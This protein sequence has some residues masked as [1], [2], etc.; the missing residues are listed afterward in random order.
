MTHYISTRGDCPPVPFDKAIIDGF[1]PDGGLY[2]P[3]TIPTFTP[4]DL[5][6]LSSLD[7]P[8][9]AQRIIRKFIPGSM[10][11]DKDLRNLLRA[12]FSPFSSPDTVPIVHLKQNNLYIQELFHGPTL[13]FK[14]I[15]MGFL[16]NCLDYFLTKRCE[17]LSLVLATTGDTGPAAA[18]AAA[19]KTS[20]ECWP[21]YPRDMISEEQERQM[22]TLDANNVHP[23]GVEN[24]LNGGDDLDIIVAKLFADNSLKNELKLS[25]VN[26]INWCRVLVQTIHYFSAY[27]KTVD[28]VGEQIAVSVPTGAFGNLCAGYIAREMGLPIN[29]FICA[30][31]A[32]ATLHRVFSTGIF[33]KQQLKQTVSSAI[34]IVIPYNFWRF[35]YF[36]SNCQSEF[37]KASMST[38]NNEGKITFMPGFH[39]ELCDGFTSYAISDTS[40]LKT[41]ATLYQADSYL[42]DPHGAVAVAAAKQ[43]QVDRGSNE[44]VVCLA[45]AHPAKFPQI[46][47]D[48]LGTDVQL[49]PE[50]THPSIEEAKQMFHHLR[51]CRYET[52]F[53][54]LPEAIRKKLVTKI[55]D[56]F[57]NR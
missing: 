29:Q 19:G 6:K 31:N 39:E 7:Y 12:S 10:M 28:Y 37:V 3:E 33:A 15:A 24:C 20:L 17:R 43:F 35:L 14:D 53:T 52:L 5:Q 1:A 2:V 44:K 27:F 55:D 18:Y 47:Q 16:I 8:E 32:N 46:I 4:A 34:D 50:A 11:P 22:T 45:T 56:E 49:P 26:S 36:K 38:F 51:L 21:L 54:A 30:T 57:K 48:A 40:T 41:I 9:L 13:S 23:V 25:S 42:L